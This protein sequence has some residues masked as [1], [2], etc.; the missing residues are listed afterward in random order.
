MSKIIGKILEELILALIGVIVEF[1]LTII[2]SALLWL[3][4]KAGSIF[5]G[6][7]WEGMKVTWGWMVEGYKAVYNVSAPRLRS[8]FPGRRAA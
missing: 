3:L 7:V 6:W 4:A 2:V 1:I 8:I 5:F